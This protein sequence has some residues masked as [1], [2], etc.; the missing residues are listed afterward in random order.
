MH[1]TAAVHTRRICTSLHAFYSPP[2]MTT[3]SHTPATGPASAAPV[4][5]APEHELSCRPSDPATAALS[6]ALELVRAVD[7]RSHGAGR[8]DDA[9]F[10][11]ANLRA[12]LR[13]WA[14]PKAAAHPHA[15][16]HPHSNSH[17][18]AHPDAAL[19]AHEEIERAHEEIERAHDIAVTPEVGSPPSGRGSPCAAD[20]MSEEELE[21]LEEMAEEAEHL[22]S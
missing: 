10:A 18:H 12:L 8:P 14:E 17:P 2:P 13:E 5:L 7:A 9:V 4:A 15:D 3:D 21:E 16:S 11:E 6:L 20:G 1:A 19:R 22:V